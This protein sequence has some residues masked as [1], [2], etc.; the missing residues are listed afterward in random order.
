MPRGQKYKFHNDYLKDKFREIW[1]NE[2]EDDKKQEY[3]E[4]AQEGRDKQREDMQS[5]QPKI[6]EAL[7]WLA[8][9]KDD[10]AKTVVDALL[11]K[12]GMWKYLKT[13]LN[14][15]IRA[16]VRAAFKQSITAWLSDDNRETW[17]KDQRK[18]GL[19]ATAEETDEENDPGVDPSTEDDGF[20]E[21]FGDSDIEEEEKGEEEEEEEE[22][23]EKEE[24]SANSSDE[25]PDDDDMGI[26]ERRTGAPRKGVLDES[27]EEE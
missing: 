21:L 23:E 6:L 15:D 8:S 18:E 26:G 3:E 27:D 20:D 9:L 2:V 7:G 16:D 14:E 1:R 5:I 11:A 25:D 13:T 4:K 10:A 12:K 17:F 22:K 19:D 24:D